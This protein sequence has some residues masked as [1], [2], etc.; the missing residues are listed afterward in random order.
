MGAKL[1]L[2]QIWMTPAVAGLP[3]VPIHSFL[4]SIP[5]RLPDYRLMLTRPNR[6]VVGNLPDVQRIGE[7]AVHILRR[8]LTATMPTV[9]TTE[10]T[11]R[12]MPRLIELI[13]QLENEVYS[14]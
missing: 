4:H 8:Q 5:Q 6:T 7:D 9:T 12:D 14:R 3:L 1:T 11:F 10:P 2:K 13:R